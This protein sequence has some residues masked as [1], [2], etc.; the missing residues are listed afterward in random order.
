MEKTAQDLFKSGTFGEA[1]ARLV[2]N[3]KYNAARQFLGG[4]DSNNVVKNLRTTPEQEADLLKQT[5]DQ[6]QSAYELLT[7]DDDRNILLSII[8]DHAHLDTS[9][10]TFSAADYE[11]EFA[12]RSFNKEENRILFETLSDHPLSATIRDQ[13]RYLPR[14]EALDH[15]AEIW[16]TGNFSG[17]LSYYTTIRKFQ[18]QAQRRVDPDFGDPTFDDDV[19][20]HPGL[21]LVI[22]RAFRANPNKFG[23][24]GASPNPVIAISNSEKSLDP[25]DD[26]EGWSEPDK[27]S[28]LLL[29]ADAPFD[30]LS[31]YLSAS[32]SRRHESR[33]HGP[34]NMKVSGD[35]NL[36]TAAYIISRLAEYSRTPQNFERPAQMRVEEQLAAARGKVYHEVY[37]Q[38]F[39]RQGGRPDWAVAA[40]L[41]LRSDK[42]PREEREISLYDGVKTLTELGFCGD[43]EQYSDQVPFSPPE[44]SREILDGFVD[45]MK[46]LHEDM[47]ALHMPTGVVQANPALSRYETTHG[48]HPDVEVLSIPE[49]KALAFQDLSDIAVGHLT[50]GFML[51]FFYEKHLSE[52]D[53]EESKPA[54]DAVSEVPM[55]EIAK[56]LLEAGDVTNFMRLYEQQQMFSKDGG[57]QNNPDMHPFGTF[58]E[59]HAR[60]AGY[61][62]LPEICIK[63]F[64]NVSARVVISPAGDILV[65]SDRMVHFK[66]PD[67]IV[68]DNR[69]GDAM[70]SLFVIDNLTYGDEFKPR[71]DEQR[72]TL[73]NFISRKFLETGIR[74]TLV[75]MDPVERHMFQSFG[76]STLPELARKM[77]EA[78]LFHEA[79]SDSF[80][81]LA[82]EVFEEITAKPTTP[83]FGRVVKAVERVTRGWVPGFR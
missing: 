2:A 80:E 26:R 4:H 12:N 70:M 28:F 81:S 24:D 29:T 44:D 72:S 36:G 41:A 19:A 83:R 57:R 82:E 64:Q 48:F 21:E 13:V 78:G 14:R 17:F 23:G 35:C 56:L 62:M 38:R 39:L 30:S 1:L 9:A 75:G 16:T 76:K 63:K 6:F 69:L 77:D 51:D 66:N 60:N 46:S 27:P 73:A 54:I 37:A 31:S 79:T 65:R 11:K 67:R 61:N 10:N 42:T 55:R 53:R 71:V 49:K 40:R 58:L 25:G 34:Y 33:G 74:Q 18:I 50:G 3:R 22:L 7:N 52:M 5:Y 8:M 59:R 68:S 32:L 20:I 45:G 15:A 47:K 43:V